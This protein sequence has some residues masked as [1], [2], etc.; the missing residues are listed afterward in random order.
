V[1]TKES[2]RAAAIKYGKGQSLDQDEER[3][4]NTASNQSGT[5]GDYLK[6]LMGGGAPDP[7]R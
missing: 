4:L 7:K 3:G 5:E 6:H 2:N 1:A